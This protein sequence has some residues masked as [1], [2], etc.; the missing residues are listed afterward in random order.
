[1][2]LTVKDRPK[3]G[4]VDSELIVSQRPLAAWSKLR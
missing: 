4:A 3:P 2:P 1:M